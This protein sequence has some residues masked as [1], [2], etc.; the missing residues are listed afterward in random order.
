MLLNGTLS[1]LLSFNIVV[2]LELSMPVTVAPT[3]VPVVT[4]LP[5]ASFAATESV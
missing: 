3:V 5:L 4:V 1:P 2:P